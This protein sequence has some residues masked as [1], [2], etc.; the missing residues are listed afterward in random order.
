MAFDLSTPTEWNKN[1]PMVY[2][3]SGLVLFASV[4]LFSLLWPRSRDRLQQRLGEGP[5]KGFYSLASVA[6]VALII[7]GYWIV[8]N[9]PETSDIV[10]Q[11][12]PGMRHVTML[13][14]LLAFIC[15]AVFHG[16]SHLRLWLKQPMSIGVSLW[17]IGHLLS[18]GRFYDILLF[19]TFLLLGVLDIVLSTMR[20]K[21]PSYVPNVRSDI[22]AVVVGGVLYVVFLFGF[23]PYVLHLPVVT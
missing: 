20:G 21:V 5:Y 17:A 18:N 3:N 4:H 12:L 19:G 8:S 6:G 16:K 1:N 2:L 22:I 7:W 23:H 14:V 9:G 11:P 13:L 10:Y 15:I